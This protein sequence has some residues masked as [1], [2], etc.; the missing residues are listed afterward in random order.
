[1]RH[2]RPMRYVEEV[3]RHGSIRRAAERL[4]VTASAINRRIADL[5]A[6]LGTMLFE[7][8]P[9]GMRPTAAGE[10][11]LA[12]IRTQAADLD[13]VR[14]QIEELRGLRRGTVRLACSQALAHRFVGS[15]IAGFRARAPLV[16]FQVTVCDH[17]AALA[18]LA[19]YEVDLVLVVGPP[20]SS[21]VLALASV[22][23]PLVAVMPEGH[24]LASRPVVRLRDLE[25]ETLVLPDRSLAGRQILDAALGRRGAAARPVVECNAFD[26]L[27]QVLRSERAVSVQFA[28][29][30]PRPGGPAEAGLVSRPF[31]PREVPA[32]TIVLGQL[33][34]RAL[35]VAA[36]RFA[37]RLASG[38]AELAA[39]GDG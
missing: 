4:N 25:G 29:G 9:R 22:E 32:A 38:L 20:R 24:R 34:E 23:Q 3:A 2:L 37:E 36:A 10:L 16:G 18:L 14:S 26:L 35:P 27:W 6:E 39:A 7:R 21:D 1:M 15:A 28:L 12:H 5:E 11:L 33:R 19:D 30:A 13:R 31:D 17:A 8:L